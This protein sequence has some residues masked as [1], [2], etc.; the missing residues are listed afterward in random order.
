[1]PKSFSIFF[2]IKIFYFFNLSTFDQLIKIWEKQ[3]ILNEGI[4]L[5]L[6]RLNRSI[7]IKI[8]FQISRL[9]RHYWGDISIFSPK[10]LLNNLTRRPIA[11]LDLS[12]N[13]MSIENPP[14][15]QLI[16]IFF[17]DLLI[18]VKLKLTSLFNKTTDS[19]ENVKKI[20]NSL[21]TCP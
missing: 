11:R 3:K 2:W 19:W 16:L 1:M 6:N 10:A 5:K 15:D 13:E 4:K 21:A 20:S 18:L 9:P 12:Q 7:C 14:L 17:R 8:T